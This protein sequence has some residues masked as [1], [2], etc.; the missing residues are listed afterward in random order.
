MTENLSIHQRAFEAE[1]STTA[2]DLL[3][4]L[5]G[6]SFDGTEPLM[7]A[8]PGA[9]HLAVRLES[10]IA[11]AARPLMLLA[12]DELVKAGFVV[13]DP[14]SGGFKVLKGGAL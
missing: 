13:A 11:T 6:L 2:H 9:T 3:S 12:A 4:Y 10:L 8:P 7:P 14:E 5:W 1:L